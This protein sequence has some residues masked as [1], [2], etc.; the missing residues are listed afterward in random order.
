VEAIRKLVPECRCLAL[1]TVGVAL[2]KQGDAACAFQILR[3]AASGQPRTWLAAYTVTVIVELDRKQT[4][5]EPYEY[6]TK[7][8]GVFSA[9]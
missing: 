5:V 3:D 8:S 7:S 4:A 2:V 9:P 6:L 1:R